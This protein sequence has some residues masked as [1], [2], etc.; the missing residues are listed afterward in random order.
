MLESSKVPPYPGG[1]HTGLQAKQEVLLNN[2]LVKNSGGPGVRP[3]LNQNP[4]ET[5]SFPPLLTNIGNHRQPVIIIFGDD[6]PK[7]FECGHRLHSTDIGLGCHHHACLHLL[8]PLQPEFLIC[9]L[10][11]FLCVSM[12][13]VQHYPRNKYIE[14]WAAQK[15]GVTLLQDHY[16][17]PHMEVHKVEPHGTSTHG[18]PQA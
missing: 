11:S 9:P 12:P 6:P 5:F 7:V 13:P 8:S 16:C 4:E 10:G 15:G 1:H 17:V 14:F 2:R 18:P 3:L